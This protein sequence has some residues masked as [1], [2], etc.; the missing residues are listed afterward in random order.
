M[1]IENLDKTANKKLCHF[2]NKWGSVIASANSNRIFSEID[3]LFECGFAPRVLLESFYHPQGCKD[4]YN[5]YTKY[6][7]QYMTQPVRLEVVCGINER[8]LETPTPLIISGD[9]P[10]S[11]YQILEGF[12]DLHGR[13]IERSSK[14]NE[15][16]NRLNQYL[17]E[18]WK[19]LSGTEIDSIRGKIKENYAE[20]V[21]KHLGE[22][23][24]IV[25][26]IRENQRVIE[27]WANLRRE[28]TNAGRVFEYGWIQ[29]ECP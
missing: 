14:C 12:D 29:E 28:L 11:L 23:E 10:V 20:I 1:G 7:E 21:S 27:M 16:K 5:N 2:N 25:K 3:E 4:S 22:P 19:Q 13:K 18:N 6:I 24:E 9:S 8:L 15:E 17:L 26:R